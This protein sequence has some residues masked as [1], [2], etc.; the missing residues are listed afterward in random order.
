MRHCRAAGLAVLVVVLLAVVLSR[1]QVQQEPSAETREGTGISMTCSHPTIQGSE[2]IQWYRQLPGKGPTFLVSAVKGS[3]ELP[4]PAGRL[5]VS[6]DR[7]SNALWLAR[8]R[9]GDAAVYYCALKMLCDSGYGYQ[10]TFGS[11]TRLVV[12]P[13]ITPSPSVYKLTSAD[14]KNLEMC[15]IT[16]YSPEKLDL[17]SVGSKTETVVEVATSENKHEVSYLSTYWA[18][19]DEMQCSAKHEGFGILEG[20]DPE[21]GVSTV[22][23]TGMSPHFK[24]DENLN[25]LTFSQLGL[26]IILLKAIIFNVL[27]TML[28]WKKNEGK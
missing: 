9:L 13:H 19:K 8:P 23:I 25:M 28:M 16:D 3:K 2:Y 10:L 4:N 11:G 6:E 22:C 5:S 7:R 26:K 27:M 21:A 1:A 12:Q 20:D 14:D 24:T 18:K 15:L 17:S